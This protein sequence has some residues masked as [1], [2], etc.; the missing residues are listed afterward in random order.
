[1]GAA[2]NHGMEAVADLPEWA[3]VQALNPSNRERFLRHDRARFI[4]TME[5]WMLAYCPREGEHVP[6]LP[7]A[8]ARALGHTCTRL[9]QRGERRPP[10]PRHIGGAGRGCPRS[11]LVEPPFGDRGGSIARVRSEEGL[12]AHWPRLA[13]QLME[14]QAEVLS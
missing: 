3:E 6:G 13:P 5:T 10:H 12:F 9:S 4:S 11:R 7:D 1:M 2:W 14:W 8:D